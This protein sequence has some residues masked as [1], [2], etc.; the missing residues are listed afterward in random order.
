MGRK[1][2]VGMET[3]RGAHRAGDLSLSYG[4]SKRPEDTLGF[5]TWVVCRLLFLTRAVSDLACFRLR[6]NLR[7]F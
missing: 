6:L 7:G 4:P 3:Y 2:R 5:F 1:I